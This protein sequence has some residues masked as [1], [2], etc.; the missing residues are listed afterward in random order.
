MV[1]VHSLALSLSA[2]GIG[3]SDLELNQTPNPKPQTGLLNPIPGEVGAPGLGTAM[4]EQQGQG[5]STQ[6]RAQ[7]TQATPVNPGPGL[8]SADRYW[9]GFPQ[10]P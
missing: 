7:T 3:A 10:Q 2:N 1:Y 4:S 6:T 9:I 8:E 5:K